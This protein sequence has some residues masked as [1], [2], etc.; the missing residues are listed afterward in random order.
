MDMVDGEDPPSGWKVMS[1][2]RKGMD[3]PKGSSDRKANDPV[4]LG[5]GM[6]VGGQN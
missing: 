4:C 6:H 2:V 5:L 3:G 1:Q